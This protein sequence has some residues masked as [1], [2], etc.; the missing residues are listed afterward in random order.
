MET[1]STSDPI[2]DCRARRDAA[3]KTVKLGRRSV[4]RF[5][6]MGAKDDGT[7]RCIACG[8][9]DEEPWHEPDLCFAIVEYRERTS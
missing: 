3:S 4:K 7:L 9:I 6:S 5:L 8:Q 1:N 2:E